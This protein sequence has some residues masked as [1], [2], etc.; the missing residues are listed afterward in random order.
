VDGHAQPPAPGHAQAPDE[1]WHTAQPGH[2]QPGHQQQPGYQQ[3]G[4]PQPGYPSPG[5]PHSGYQHPYGGG[6]LGPTPPQGP[7]P[8]GPQHEPPR[9]ARSTALLIV[10]AL[11]VALGAGG[12][13]YALMRGDGADTAG[14]DPTPTR[15]TGAP[16]DPG[17]GSPGTSDPAAG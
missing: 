14:G 3:Q 2:H 9:S 10:V 5:Y 17:S 4:H 12:T 1:G 6:G 8:Y 11:I 13:V 16:Q 7:P 15:S